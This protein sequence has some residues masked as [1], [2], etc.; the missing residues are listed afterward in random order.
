MEIPVIHIIFGEIN[1][2]DPEL[3]NMNLFYF[4]RTSEEAIPSFDTLH[5]SNKQMEDYLNVGSLNGDF[6]NTLNKILIHVS[7]LLFCKH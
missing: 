1:L 2:N 5:M 6:L 4:L 7:L 3:V